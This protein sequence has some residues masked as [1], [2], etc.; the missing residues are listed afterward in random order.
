MCVCVCVC[1]CVCLPVL[2]ASRGVC[3]AYC[4]CRRLLCLPVHTPLLKPGHTQQTHT[5]RHTH[6]H[7]RQ[8]LHLAHASL[9]AH[10]LYDMYQGQLKDTHTH[11]RSSAGQVL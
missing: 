6:T 7:R 5:Y 1:V 3:G 4:R 11:T 10:R 9:L 2:V 8:A